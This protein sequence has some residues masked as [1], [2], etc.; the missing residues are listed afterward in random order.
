MIKRQ[1]NYK[2]VE[3][4]MLKNH[5]IKEIFVLIENLTKSY[6]NR[7]T[8]L[9]NNYATLLNAYHLQEHQPTYIASPQQQS[10]PQ[11]YPFQP[12]QQEYTPPPIQTQETTDLNEHQK[13]HQKIERSKK[14]KLQ[15]T[16][17]QPIIDFSNPFAPLFLTEHNHNKRDNRKYRERKT[18]RAGI[19]KPPTEKKRRNESGRQENLVQPNLPD[20]NE[21][22]VNDE[23]EEK[24]GDQ[25]KTNAQ[26]NEL[27]SK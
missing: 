6:Q 1:S 11:P 19:H 10:F 22:R 26:D 4:E 15:A 18:V 20:Q 5:T 17:N 3:L 24:Q 8:E 13:K 7:I 2:F 9:E 14:N 27:Q 25:Q 16:E 21:Q 23:K 12:P